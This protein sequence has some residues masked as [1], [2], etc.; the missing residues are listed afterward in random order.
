VITIIEDF[1]PLAAGGALNGLPAGE[2]GGG[3][4]ASQQH[5]IIMH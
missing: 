4:G 2:A 5:Q 1:L 3:G